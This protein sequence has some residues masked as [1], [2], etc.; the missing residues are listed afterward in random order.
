MTIP[1]VD[2]FFFYFITSKFPSYF[3]QII[4]DTKI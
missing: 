1:I 4:V 2:G 3:S